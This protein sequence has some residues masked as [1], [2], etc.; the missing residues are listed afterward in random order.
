[1]TISVSTFLWVIGIALAIIFGLIGVIWSVVWSAISR[2]R[3]NQAKIFDGAK[4]DRDR[5]DAKFE[6]VLQA[7]E[8][9]RKDRMIK[10]DATTERIF[11]EIHKVQDKTSDLSETV[12]GFGTIYVTRREVES[13]YRG[14]EM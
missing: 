5:C 10:H 9:E 7:I 3:N 2:L 11:R 14:K 1:M 8:E 4:D 12:A 13:L 6:R